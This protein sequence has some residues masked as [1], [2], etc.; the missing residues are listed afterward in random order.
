MGDYGGLAA[1]FEEARQIQRE[2]AEKAA[3]PVDCPICG[4]PLEYNEKRGLLGC[5]MGHWRQSG[6]P[7]ER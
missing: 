1:I 2:E 4:E 3:H 5:P 6:R 7:R